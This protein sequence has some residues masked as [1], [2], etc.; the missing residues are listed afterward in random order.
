MQQ[1]TFSSNL[2][3]WS[4]GPASCTSSNFSRICYKD[5]W[6]CLQFFS[7]NTFTFS[8][9][10]TCLLPPSP[11]RSCSGQTL[12]NPPSLKHDWSNWKQKTFNMLCLITA[13]FMTTLVSSVVEVVDGGP[14]VLGFRGDSNSAPCYVGIERI[15]PIH[16]MLEQGLWKLTALPSILHL[17]YKRVLVSEVG[18]TQRR[19]LRVD[20]DWKETSVGPK[21]V[22]FIW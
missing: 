11:C 20:S 17:E 3:W 8:W 21:W 16:P 18:P 13:A 12:V 22:R 4:A 2:K 19:I 5:Q 1:V 15:I 7:I 9:L 14:P 6:K 10:N